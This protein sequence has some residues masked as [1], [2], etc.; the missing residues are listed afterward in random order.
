MFLSI[1]RSFF[2]IGLI[3]FG[4]PAAHIALLQ[5]EFIDKRNWI[6]SKDFLSLVGLTHLIPGPN[7]TEMVM[8]LGSVRYGVRGMLAS[9]FGFIIPAFLLSLFLTVIYNHVSNLDY[10]FYV[11]SF[12]KP[13]LLSLVFFATYQLFIKFV[14]TLKSLLFCILT[15]ILSFFG[16][17]PVL[18]ICLMG[19]FSVS[20]SFRC[21]AKLYSLFSPVLLSMNFSSPNHNLFTTL[22]PFLKIGSTLFGG[23]F[24]L[25]AFAQSLL[26]DRLHLLTSSELLHAIFIGQLTPGPIIT[27]ATSMGYLIDGIRGACLA[28]VGIFLPSLFFVFFLRKFISMFKSTPYFVNF[29]DGVNPAALGLMVY[30][31]FLLSRDLVFNFTSFVTVILSLLFLFFKP[32]NLGVLSLFSTSALIGSVLYFVL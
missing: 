4:G 8:H 21:S 18:V 29:L 27:A 24:V 5:S 1:F 31:S 15:I 32:C 28:T 19:L 17:N 25:V 9:S 20:L 3:A 30:A 23:G 14:S 26:V 11:L 10:F 2:W 12:L 22:V 16:F 6:S 13:V 7:S